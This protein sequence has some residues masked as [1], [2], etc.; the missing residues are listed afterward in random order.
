MVAWVVIDRQHLRQTSPSLF[1]CSHSHFGCHASRIPEEIIPFFSCTYV[2]PILQPLCFHIHV[3]NVGPA[4]DLGGVFMP[5]GRPRR[6][7][8]PQGRSWGQG[9]K[10]QGGPIP[11]YS[12]ALKRPGEL[13]RPDDEPLVTCGDL[14]FPKPPR[15]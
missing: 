13:P 10:M 12:G 15:R 3:C 8:V 2:E 11:V 14:D 4:R 9:K 5:R 1:P 7:C 6:G